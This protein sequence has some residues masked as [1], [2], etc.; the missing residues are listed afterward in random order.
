MGWYQALLPM[1]IMCATY[2]LSH[3]GIFGLDYVQNDGKVRTGSSQFR[4]ALMMQ[5]FFHACGG[6]PASIMT[7]VSEGTQSEALAFNTSRMP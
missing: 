3:Y 1:G 7:A 5:I 4:G 6:S 2:A